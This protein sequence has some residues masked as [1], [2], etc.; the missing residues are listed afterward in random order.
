MSAPLPALITSPRDRVVRENP[1]SS[2]PSKGDQSA[3]VSISDGVTVCVRV[4]WMI[5]RSASAPIW[6]APLRGASPMIAAGLVLSFRHISSSVSRPS[7]TPF[8]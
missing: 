1:A 5:A 7:S 6:I 2:Q 8:V 3:F 4:G